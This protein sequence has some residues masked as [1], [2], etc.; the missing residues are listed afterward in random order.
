LLLVVC[1]AVAV[2]TV[3]LAGG[4]LARLA[5]LSLARA[6]AL[7]VAL[8]IQVLIISVIPEGAP[9]LHAV[10]HVA[11]YGF[12]VAF[13]VANRGVPGLWLVAIGAG[14]NL[15]AI[16]AN[17]GVMPASRAALAR[18]G[19]SVESESFANSAAVTD[20][21]LAFLGDIFAVPQPL[22]FANVFSVG[23]VCIVLGA[24]LVVHRVCDSRL[25][26][27]RRPRSPRRTESGEASA[28]R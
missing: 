2:L 15:V 4:R 28:T 17:G 1:F 21:K 9:G 19:Q 12:V 10:A 16:A 6:W 23:D 14:L 18:A 27:G 3:P 13:L 26:L 7:G 20:A 24:A 22:P 11:S 25:A 8:A 5:S